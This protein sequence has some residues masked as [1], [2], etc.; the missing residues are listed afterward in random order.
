M[1]KPTVTGLAYT[2]HHLL[3]MALFPKFNVDR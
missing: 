2:Y 1:N 3:I